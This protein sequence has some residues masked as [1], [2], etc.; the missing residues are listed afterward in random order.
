EPAREPQR[1]QRSAEKKS[2]C[3]TPRPPRFLLLDPQTRSVSEMATTNSMYRFALVYWIA[4]GSISPL[5]T[6][7]PK[8]DEKTISKGP[9]AI[10]F[11]NQKDAEPKFVV[12]GLSKKDLQ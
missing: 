8:P 3:A 12:S 11:Q 2:L 7:E 5:T 1:A 6:D 4:A 9:I 10:Q